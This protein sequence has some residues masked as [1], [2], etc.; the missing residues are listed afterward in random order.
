MRDHGRMRLLLVRHGQTPSNVGHHLDTAE[1][2][3]ELTELGRAQAAAIPA[4]LD[5]EEVRAIYVSTLVRTQQT[6][7]PLATA[8]GLEPVVRDGIREIAAGDL[9]MR[10]DETSIRAYIDQVF[11]WESDLEERM[12]G[13]ESGAE[14][15]ARFDG[16]VREAHAQVGDT[17]TALIV[18]H[19]AMI[20]M[21]AASRASNIDLAY[22]SDT[23]LANT[24]MVALETDATG[25]WV[26]DCWTQAALG[27]VALT[28][29]AHIGP[30]GEPDDDPFSPEP[31]RTAGAPVSFVRSGGPGGSGD[32]RDA[33]GT[34]GSESPGL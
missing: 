12:P 29:P 11:G 33:A 2:G 22:A 9:E 13:G 6:A 32:S 10:N 24:A 25:G 26:V 1:P 4:A 14:V 28:D 19:G 34:G 8:L 16:V 7:A 31:T 30:G 5:R 20:R 15:L 21:W 3:A 18:S 17:G 23:A 27:G